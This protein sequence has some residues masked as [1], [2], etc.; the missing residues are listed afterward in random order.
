MDKHYEYL[1]SVAED[2]RLQLKEGA[3]VESIG[4]VDNDY[5]YFLSTGIN[6]ISDFTLNG[7]KYYFFTAE[8]A[9]HLYSVFSD[10]VYVKALITLT[11]VYVLSCAFLCFYGVKLYNKKEE[12]EKYKDKYTG[13]V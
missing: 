1:K 9:N 13:I 10:K 11:V 4:T 5:P 8:T 6:N 12:D 2:Y 7:Q 3:T